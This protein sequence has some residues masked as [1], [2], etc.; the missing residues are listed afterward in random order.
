M[1]WGHRRRLSVRVR[2]SKLTT[3]C[4]ATVDQAK[5]F[6]P[7][8]RAVAHAQIQWR[9]KH[10]AQIDARLSWNLP[11]NL[12]LLIILR[13]TS[14]VFFPQNNSRSTC[15]SVLNYGSMLLLAEL[16]KHA[17]WPNV[18]R[19]VSNMAHTCWIHVS[20]WIRIQ[21]FEYGLDTYPWLIRGL[22]VSVACVSDT[23]Y[24]RITAHAPSVD[25]GLPEPL[26]RRR[27]FPSRS[28]N[29]IFCCTVFIETFCI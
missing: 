28:G 20:K 5:K 17:G 7:T 12:L 3:E 27:F 13:P 16:Q 18:S 9:V 10:V 26:D 2:D 19:A 11:K 15:E 4:R 1:A 8:T 29:S 6:G 14:I 24:P 25:P 23:G 21:Y 22:S